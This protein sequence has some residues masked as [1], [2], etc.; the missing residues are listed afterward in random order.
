M[1]VISI[2]EAN[3][4]MNEFFFAVRPKLDER[5]EQLLR[6][7][8]NSPIPPE[9]LTTFVEIVYANHEIFTTEELAP[10]AD[11]AEF[12]GNFMFLTLRD[13][14]GNKIAAFLRGEAVED[15][16]EP[17]QRYAPPPEEE[18]EEPPVPDLPPPPEQP[19]GM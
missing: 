8:K 4:A 1:T 2:A 13:M 7:A 15:M 12:G 18:P 10:V 5:L 3:D 9:S 14:R 6:D 17:E 16:P 11:V 19:E